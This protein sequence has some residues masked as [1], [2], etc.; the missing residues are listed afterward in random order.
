MVGYGADPVPELVNA[1]QIQCCSSG[2]STAV[3]MFFRDTGVFSHVAQTAAS[4]SPLLYRPPQ[5]VG[6]CLQIIG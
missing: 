6:W 3:A 5:V 2:V 4:V 1:A